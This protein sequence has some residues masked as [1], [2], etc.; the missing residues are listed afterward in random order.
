M[1]FALNILI[2]I[3]DQIMLFI[4]NVLVARNV[5]E[6]LFGDFSV[7]TN[8]LLLLATLITLGLDS[9]IAYYIPKFFIQKKYDEI[10]ALT[11]SIKLFIKPI[12]F[13]VTTVGLVVAITLIA[14]SK[15]LESY[16]QFAY[17]H[18]MYLFLWGLVGISLYTIFIQLFRSIYYMR[19]SVILSFIQTLLY[20]ALSIII[21]R[22]I[23]RLI[24]GKTN[25]YFVYL[26]LS[27]F[28]LSYILTVI[29]SFYLILRTNIKFRNNH[30]S[31]FDYKWKEKILGYTVQKLDPFLFST[32][33]LIVMEWLA[34][35]EKAVGLFAAVSSIIS[36]AFIAIRPIGILIGP[37]ISAALSQSREQLYATMSKFM[38]ICLTIALI[39]AGTFGI[40]AKQ[41]LLIYKS[42]FI[43]ALPYLY[44]SLINIVTYSISMPLSKM[45]MYSKNGSKIGSRLTIALLFIQTVSCLTLTY[46]FG[47]K[48]AITCFVGINIIY[49][50]AMLVIAYS[51]YNNELKPQSHAQL[52]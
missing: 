42:N 22:Y 49:N 47:I 44:I 14:T 4:I 33:P 29:L 36:L 6:V 51:I 50:S 5:G 52:N 15:A 26:M 21:Y 2:I 1:D 18:P 32:I 11:T 24:L 38:K 23:Y 43:D 12:Y 7:A 17:A 46:W 35:Q 16:H 25:H 45:I 34:H 30:H 39:I 9:I 19:T 20:F 41:I 37:E 27:G 13:S 28:I 10:V 48:G 8:G 31:Q 3:A 40:F